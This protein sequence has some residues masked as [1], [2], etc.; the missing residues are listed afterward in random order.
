M[1]KSASE[2]DLKKAYRKLALQFHPDKNKAPGATEA[3][4]KIGKA[5]AILNDSS[6]RK[7][8][9]QLGPDSFDGGEMSSTTSSTRRRGDYHRGSHYQN[10]YSWND[11]DFSADE[12]FNLFFGVTPTH[13]RGRNQRAHHTSYVFTDPGHGAGNSHA[14]LFQLMPILLIVVLTL[15]SNLLTGDP[16]YSLHKTEYT[17]SSIFKIYYFISFEI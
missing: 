5:F 11:E 13:Q 10:H 6:K 9:D 14:V 15:L 1:P 8:Y 3:F 16:I 12:L 7:Q 2:A 4:K 17:F